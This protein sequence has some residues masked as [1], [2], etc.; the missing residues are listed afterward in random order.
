MP[1]MP[2]LEPAGVGATCTRCGAQAARQAWR[3]RPRPSHLW[4]ISAARQPPPRL[5]PAPASG[6]KRVKS[7]FLKSNLAS[8]AQWH[9]AAYWPYRSAKR[10]LLA[11]PARPTHTLGEETV[12]KEARQ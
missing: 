8:V 12:E 9:A 4:V 11:T 2:H 10:A 5:W 6:A 7:G 1:Q 3:R